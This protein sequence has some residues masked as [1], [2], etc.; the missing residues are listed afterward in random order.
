MRG[1]FCRAKSASEG[2]LTTNPRKPV[3]CIPNMF[4]P[5]G[6]VPPIQDACDPFLHRP[7]NVV[8]NARLAVGEYSN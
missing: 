7:T 2:A 4:D 3:N 8:R 5:Q 6:D 1:P